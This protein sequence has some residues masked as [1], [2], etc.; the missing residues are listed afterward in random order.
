MRLYSGGPPTAVGKVQY[1]LCTGTCPEVFFE[2]VYNFPKWGV[3]PYILGIPKCASPF[4]GNL[5]LTGTYLETPNV[6]W[7]TCSFVV[8]K[9]WAQL[10][11]SFEVYSNSLVGYNPY[12]SLY[13]PLINQDPETNGAHFVVHSP[14]TYYIRLTLQ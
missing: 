8:C 10:G 7:P 4:C 5:D 13:T 12:M 6:S 2:I 9:A 3:T 11:C 1:E 14:T